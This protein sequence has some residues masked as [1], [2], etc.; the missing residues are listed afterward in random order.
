MNCHEEILPQNHLLRSKFFSPPEKVHEE[1]SA[2]LAG[3]PQAG[4]LRSLLR[5][6]CLARFT[7]EHVV[8]DVLH[9][10]EISSSSTGPL[11]IRRSR[12]TLSKA[13]RVGS[14][15]GG[16]LSSS[17]YSCFLSSDSS[18]SEPLSLLASKSAH[19]E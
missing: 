2:W 18:T 15:L 14:P 7:S 3:G 12:V 10:D 11:G 5:G 8:N 9:S 17:L 1:L 6:T 16:R 4:Y 13:F 19:F